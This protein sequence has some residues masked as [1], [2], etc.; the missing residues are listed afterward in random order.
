MHFSCKHVICIPMLFIKIEN[1][2][3]VNMD[4]WMTP[5]EKSIKLDLCPSVY[6]YWDLSEMLSLIVS[7][8]CL[9]TN[10]NI[11][12]DQQNRMPRRSTNES[13][14]CCFLSIIILLKIHYIWTALT[15][16]LLSCDNTRSE[17]Y[18][19]FRNFFLLLAQR[20]KQRPTCQRSVSNISNIP[21][22]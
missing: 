8:Y 18:I 21:L 10:N 19:S 22:L 16:V 5:V 9:V 1:K 2:T 11:I 12:G 3:R 4:P 14:Q 17:T 15:H 20:F 13:A 6:T 7:L